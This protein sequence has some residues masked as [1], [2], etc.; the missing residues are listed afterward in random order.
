MRR[1]LYDD[2]YTSTEGVLPDGVYGFYD[3]FNFP[4][5]PETDANTE[6]W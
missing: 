3:N 5:G 6:A 1:R 2:D 4:T